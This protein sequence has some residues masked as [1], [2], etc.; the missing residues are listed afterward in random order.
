MFLRVQDRVQ[1]CVLIQ[2]GCMRVCEAVR[3]RTCKRRWPFPGEQGARL[4]SSGTCWTWILYIWVITTSEI[5]RLLVWFFVC[6]SCLFV[7][8]TSCSL[9]TAIDNKW[10]C[11]SKNLKQQAVNCFWPVGCSLLA[12]GLHRRCKKLRLHS[13]GNWVVDFEWCSTCRKGVYGTEPEES[14]SWGDC[15]E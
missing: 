3:G 12:P 14:G 11:C 7:L 10:V 8:M 5:G 1:G 4:R 2:D 13:A 9:K 15:W 6:F